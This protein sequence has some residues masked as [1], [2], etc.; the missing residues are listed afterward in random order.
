MRWGIF[1]DIH[2]NLEAFRAVLAALAKE[3][4]DKYLFLGDIVGYGADPSECIAEIK[5]LSP[6]IIA[7]NH[8]WASVG[9]FDIA[10]FNPQ[11]KAAVL[12]TSQNISDEDKQ[13]LRNLRLIYQEDELT[14]V[15]GSLC[16]PE[17][18]KYIVDIYSAK[19]NFPQLHTKICFIGHTH[20]PVIFAQEGERYTTTVQSKIRLEDY[21]N[22]IVN[23]GSVGQPRDGNPQAAYVVY[24]SEKKLV[25]IKRVFYDIIRAQQRIIKAGLPRI[26][27]ERLAVGR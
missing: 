9:L 5:K 10:Y 16:N 14:L 7:G 6:E 26:L 3:Q 13:F 25:Q 27:A 18:F 19:E 23:V 17:Q 15:H 2:S 20:A 1:S 22:Y 12:W 24:D 21:Q 8:D 4:I 11:A